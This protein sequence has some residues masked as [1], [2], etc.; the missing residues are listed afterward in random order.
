MRCHTCGICIALTVCMMVV[1]GVIPVHAGWVEVD[2]D[3]GK[4]MM[5]KGRVKSV[6]ED[7]WT[8]FNTKSKQM[9]IVD[10]SRQ[11]YARGTIDDY[12]RMM[13]DVQ[14]RMSGFSKEMENQMRNM[15]PE[16]RAM[17]EEMIGQA[18]TTPPGQQPMMGQKKPSKVSVIKKGS[19][20]VI[21]GYQTVKYHVMVDG[22]LSKGI[23]LSNDASLAEALKERENVLKMMDRVEQCMSMD[24]EM[25]SMPE[26]S[27]E[28]EKLI[29]KGWVMKEVSGDETDVDVITL[30]Q[31]SLSD[32]EFTLLAAYQEVAI[33]DMFDPPMAN[34]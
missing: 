9:T 29:R 2:R 15:S 25:V 6:D 27:P 34:E 16:Q 18:G 26:Y 13:K 20:G 3:G 30:E 1:G 4:V 22:G 23:W 12:C 5:S 10:S 24:T 31:R 8:L 33:P 21:A 7:G 11:I 14:Q 19:G 32:S 28:Y 17:M